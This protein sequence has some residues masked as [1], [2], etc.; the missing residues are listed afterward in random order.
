[1]SLLCSETLQG[2]FRLTHNCTRIAMVFRSSSKVGTKDPVSAHDQG[3]GLTLVVPMVSQA[4]LIERFLDVDS[5]QVCNHTEPEDMSQQAVN[6]KEVSLLA[7]IE[8]SLPF[9]NGM[10]EPNHVVR[11]T[12]ESRPASPVLQ[13]F[14]DLSDVELAQEQDQDT[15]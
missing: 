7:E 14:I 2:R 6:A 3:S 12:D 4:K 8:E 10:A 11:A 5:Q 15:N 13:A 1:M 9:P